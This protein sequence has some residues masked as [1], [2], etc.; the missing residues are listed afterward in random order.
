MA[1]CPGKY[2]LPLAE[3]ERSLL[4][5]WNRWECNMTAALFFRNCLWK[6]NFGYVGFKRWFA[7]LGPGGTHVA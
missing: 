3:R 7:Q 4:E 5:A 6:S 1:V 2:H